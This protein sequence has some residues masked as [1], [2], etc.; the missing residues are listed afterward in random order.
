MKRRWVLAF[1]AILLAALIVWLL[2]PDRSLEAQIGRICVGMTEQEVVDVLGVVA[3]DYR[4][5]RESRLSVVNEKAEG[6]NEV[7]D[8]I[9][10]ESW[11]WDECVFW[12]FFDEK[13]QL[14]G[15][16]VW[17]IVHK[18]FLQRLKARFGL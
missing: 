9:R 7:R 5:K 18:S 3:G 16:T 1:L 8:S 4:S 10:S 2:W 17:R 11:A 12:G 6:L 15:Y 14:V 13:Q